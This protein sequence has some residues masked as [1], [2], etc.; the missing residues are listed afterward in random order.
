MDSKK[1]LVCIVGPTA[2]GKTTLAIQLAQYLQTEI[3]SADSRQFYRELSIGTAKPTPEELSAAPHHFINTKS[4]AE[5]YSAGDFEVDALNV[6]D[7]LFKTKNSVI[8]VG[9]SGMYIDAVCKGF[10][11]LPNVTKSIRDEIIA[12]Y[13]KDGIAFLQEELRASDPEYLT[14]VDTKNPQRLMR[15]VE[16][17]RETGKPFSHYLKH[18]TAVRN[19]HSITIG[20]KWERSELYERI[21]TRVD[22]MIRNGL[23][24]E[25]R[26]NIQYKDNY[27]LRTVGYSEFY[28]YFEGK[29]NLATTI[30]L[31]K[32][33]SRNFAKRQL[34]WFK[35]DPSI[36]WIDAKE[37]NTIFAM[38]KN[39][40]KVE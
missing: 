2:S 26:Q 29:Q 25:A 14:M 20:I 6:I 23:E 34:T 15:A 5:T 17:F 7:Q 3:V 1:T 39:L 10:D 36:T 33:H 22:E 13:K 8:L 35:R 38:L 16:V 30:D 37:K 31:I 28:D 40:I 19:F 24:E 9:G 12:R 32:Q 27:A 4:I 18:K 11:A 21:N